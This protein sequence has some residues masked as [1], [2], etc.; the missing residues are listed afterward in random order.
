MSPLSQQLLTGYVVTGRCLQN[1]VSFGNFLSFTIRL[2]PKKRGDN[3]VLLFLCDRRGGVLDVWSASKFSISL[4]HFPDGGIAHMPHVTTHERRPY[5]SAAT[6]SI[7]MVTCV[8]GK[9]KGIGLTWRELMTVLLCLTGW[10][11]N[12]QSLLYSG[13]AY[14]WHI[15]SEVRLKADVQF[16]LKFWKAATPEPA[17]KQSLRYLQNRPS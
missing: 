5:R 9:Q 2:P 7:R 14:L 13:D 1:L 4:S 12:P 6:E 10:S 8:L 11:P 3:F 16:V 15:R 17:T